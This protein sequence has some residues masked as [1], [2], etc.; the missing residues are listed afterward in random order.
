VIFTDQDIRR[1]VG[2]MTPEELVELDRLLKGVS[3][4]RPLPGPQSEAFSSPADIMLY[5]GAAGG[6]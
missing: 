5:G 4:W 2:R 1:A 3:P 6:G